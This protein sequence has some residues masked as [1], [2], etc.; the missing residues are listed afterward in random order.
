MGE[1]HMPATR[2]ELFG[3]LDEL[4]I[5]YSTIEHEAAH[6]VEDSR[7]LRGDL[8]GG[9]AKNLFLKSKKGEMVLIVAHENSRIKLNQ[10]YKYLGTARLSFASA[11]MMMKYLGV[12][13]GSVTPFALINDIDC[14]VRLILD[15]C[16]M[17]HD[18]LNFHP[19]ENTATTTISRSDL[20]KFLRSCGHEVEIVDVEHES[21][22]G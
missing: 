22:K 11:E 21:M 18:P 2:S 12:R 19:L 7:A 17:R 20:L 6:R 8:P 10:L 5:A 14:R 1:S 15:T 13:P 9:H 16:L 4:G 3:R